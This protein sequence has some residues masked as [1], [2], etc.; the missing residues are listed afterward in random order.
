MTTNAQARVICDKA[1][2]T[3]GIITPTEVIMLVDFVTS[4]LDVEGA[5]P[6]TTPPTGQ[7]ELF[8]REFMD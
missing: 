4:V 1:K 8:P 3:Q 2:R 6:V 5:E 7:R